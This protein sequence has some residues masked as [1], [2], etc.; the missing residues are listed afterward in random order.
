M[1]TKPELPPLLPVDVDGIPASMLD[2]ARWAPWRA[3]WNEKKR[4]YEKIPHRAEQ[5]A[6]GLST[7]STKGWAPFHVAMAV[8]A[9]NPGKFAGVGY[10]VTG[11]KVSGAAA[12]VF[13]PG[14]LAGVDLDH[15]RDAA[16][17]EIAPWAAEVIAKLDSY[18]EVSPSG[19]G[20]R[21]MVRAGLDADTIDHQQGIEI[22]GGTQARFVTI[23]GQRVDGSRRDV[24]PAPAGVL[25][26]LAA[27]YRRQRTKAEVEDLHLPPLMSAMDLP[28]LADLDLPPHAANFLAE[29]PDPGA[30]RSNS[31]FATA[32][33]L[34]QAGC[35]REQILSMLEA[36][37][38]AME[39]ALDHRRQD[40]DKALRYLWKDH[41]RAG[42]ARA[43]EIDDELRD[44]FE[45]LEPLAPAG[46]PDDLEDLLGGAP[47]D[48]QRQTQAESDPA[49]DFE[50]LDAAEGVAPVARDLSPVRRE[51]FAVSGAGEFASGPPQQWIIKGLL[52]KAQVGMIYG[53]STAGKSFVAM[54]MLGSIARGLPWR[55]MRTRQGRVV[56]VVAE[57]LMGARGRLKAYAQHHDVDLAE[58]PFGIIGDVPSMLL[59]EDVKALAKQ[60]VDWG[61]A[62][63]IVLDTLAQSSA[64][65]NENS[66]EDM[67]KV[68][69]HCR[70]LNKMTGAMVL[71]VHHA[72]KDASR[73]ARGWSGLKGAMDVEIEVTRSKLLGRNIQLSKAKDGD[74]GKA[75]GFKLHVVT[76]GTDEDGDPITSCVV[77][78]STGAA[79][80]EDAKDGLKEDHR[81]VLRVLTEA[82]DLDADLH[83]ED[84]R[85]ATVPH[86]EQ[87]GK[88]DN[89]MR[90]AGKAI[91]KLEALGYVQKDEQSRYTLKSQE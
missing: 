83:Y 61:G 44:D 18:T 51:K 59:K 62:D 23:T 58:V 73:G 20:L 14:E 25:E 75:M 11:E 56:L 36:N 4:K 79:V 7:K 45:Q 32:I 70:G 55:G 22:Y 35:S 64:G 26:G 65:A 89:R 39:V 80:V 24:R 78:H 19:T 43:K 76:I 21:V 77:E 57:G 68:L 63:I 16:T 67:G 30:D 88:V 28:D 41:C 8:Y 13:A 9:Q 87:R 90:D 3:V 10:L 27:K 38:H 15:C 86:M 71:L 34:A 40:Y 37:E 5:P 33:A 29:G 81:A 52:P 69:A 1:A 47:V 85:R 48:D 84:L 60:V 6:Y 46:V 72:G 74:E 54:D 53:E 2:T 31:L 12:D 49:N 50:D 66:G 82:A 91:E 42:A 17:G